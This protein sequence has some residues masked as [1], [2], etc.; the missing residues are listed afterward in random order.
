MSHRPGAVTWQVVGIIMLIPGLLHVP[1]PQADFH[2]IRHHHKVGEVC[3]H[4]DHLLRW[5]P[6]ADEAEDV[7]VLHWHWLL[8]E[9]LDLTPDGP[10]PILHAHVVDSLQP[11]WNA[12]QPALSPDARDRASASSDLASRLDLALIG[13]ALNDSA[14]PDQPCPGPGARRANDAPPRTALSRLVRWNC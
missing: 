14:R 1:L 5:H 11:E 3:P 10:A 4:H 6:Q 9:P 12:D 8:P 2:V 13:V 7:A